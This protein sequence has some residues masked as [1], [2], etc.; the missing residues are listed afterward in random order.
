MQPRKPPGLGI[1][2]LIFLVIFAAGA[3]AAVQMKTAMTSSNPDS[4]PIT[5]IQ[6]TPDTRKSQGL[7]LGVFYPPTQ[8]L[9][10]APV[11]SSP[12]AVKATPKSSMN[13]SIPVPTNSYSPLQPVCTAIVPVPEPSFCEQIAN[14]PKGSW[15]DVVGREWCYP[16]QCSKHQDSVGIGGL[17]NCGHQ[18]AAHCNEGTQLKIPEL[19]R[20]YMTLSCYDINTKIGINSDDMK[21]VAQCL[22]YY[23]KYPYRIPQ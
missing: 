23:K 18:I 20:Y 14:D 19:W 12:T 3:Y 9:T 6:P 8:A 2:L 21:V 17:Q 10:K 15:E 5:Q 16:E 1:I 4:V 11:K 7:H 22:A 13:P